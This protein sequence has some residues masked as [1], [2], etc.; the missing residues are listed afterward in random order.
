[1]TKKVLPITVC[2]LVAGCSSIRKAP[3]SSEKMNAYLL[4]KTT[5]AAAETAEDT[6][7]VPKLQSLTGL[8]ARQSKAVLEYYGKPRD[9]PKTTVDKLLSDETKGISQLAYK[10]ASKADNPHNI[11]ND[12]LEIAIGVSGVIGGAFGLKATA[13]LSSA[14][15]KAQALQE[16]INGNENFKKTYPEYSSLFKKSQKDQSATTK[17]IV[18]Q[19][20]NS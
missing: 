9:I 5:Q 1:M 18:T 13:F 12:F 14:K 16:I 11:L 17:K 15:Q 6:Q 2:L 7:A 20:K 3:D 8:A 19:V 10:N 4:S